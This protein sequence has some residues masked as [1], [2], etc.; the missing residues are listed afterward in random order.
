V[1]HQDRCGYTIRFVPSLNLTAFKS[2]PRQDKQLLLWYCLRAIDATGRGVLGQE[3]AI[4]I[5]RASFGYQRQ[6][7]YKHL[8]ARDGIYWHHCSVVGIATLRGVAMLS[9]G[10]S[11]NN[12]R[13]F[14][15]SLRVETGKRAQ[16]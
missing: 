2:R 15:F 10:P 11:G 1:P 14:P 5:L 16:A 6:T 4:N 9:Q 7:C 8:Q 13:I 12:T 3:E